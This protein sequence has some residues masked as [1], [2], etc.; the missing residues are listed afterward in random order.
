MAEYGIVLSVIT[1]GAVVVLTAFG[2]AAA[3]AVQ[4]VVGLL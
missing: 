2:G 3:G 1:I 4:R